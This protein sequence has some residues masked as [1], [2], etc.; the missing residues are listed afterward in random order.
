MQCFEVL[1]W[2]SSTAISKGSKVGR[3]KVRSGN[4]WCG[5]LAQVDQSKCTMIGRQDEP[6]QL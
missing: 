5:I 2:M 4:S 1:T 6:W 3:N